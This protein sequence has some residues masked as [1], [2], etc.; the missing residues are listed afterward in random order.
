MMDNIK[1]FWWPLYRWITVIAFPF[2]IIAFY[3]ISSKMYKLHKVYQTLYQSNTSNLYT[4]KN[5]KECINDKDDLFKNFRK[6][7]N[8]SIATVLE[9]Y[10]D[11]KTVQFDISEKYLKT[12]K[13]PAYSEALRIADLKKVTKQYI[14]DYKQIKYRYE[15]ILNLYPELGIY[16]EDFESV[17]YLES[18]INEVT[19][20]Y[21]KTRDY[22]TKEEYEKLDVNQRNQLALDNYKK[23][24]KSNWQIGRDYEMYC[25]YYLRKEGSKVNENGSFKK[26]EDLGRDLIAYNND[27]TIWVIQCKNWSSEKL[28]HEKHIAQL[29]GTTVMFEMDNYSLFKIEIVPVFMTTI[30]LSETAKKFADRLGVLIIDEFKHQ[31]FPR[32]K[33]NINNGNKIYHLPFDQQYDRTKIENEGEFY[34]Y[35]VNDAVLKGFR[36]AFKHFGN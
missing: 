21:D 24:K 4:I 6:L 31:E 14:V 33:C 30:T 35:S 2:I 18:D 16:L 12:K 13:H 8:V 36:R 34:A 22:L 5:L 3:D 25:A 1:E 32:I 27:G 23:G 9:L 17:K 15:A 26:L 19:D 29:Y 11:F 28:I 7:D 20:N 10:S